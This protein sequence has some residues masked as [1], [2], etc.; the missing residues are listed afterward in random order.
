MGLGE[1]KKTGI[2]PG[3]A[4]VLPVD[5]GKPARSVPSWS[6]ARTSSILSRVQNSSKG[7]GGN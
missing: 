4:G 5:G 3:C 1:T 7:G 6:T 2:D